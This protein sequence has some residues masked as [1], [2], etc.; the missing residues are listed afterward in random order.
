MVTEEQDL[1]LSRIFEAGLVMGTLLRAGL[2][3]EPVLDEAGNYT[4]RIWL[5]IFDATDLER[6][7][8]RVLIEIVTG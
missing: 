4:T 5:P 8:L 6:S 3:P 2:H 7:E 1:R